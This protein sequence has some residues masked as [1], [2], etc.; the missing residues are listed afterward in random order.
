MVF[1]IW[2]Q[3]LESARARSWQLLGKWLRGRAASGTCSY[4]A[5]TL[6]NSAPEVD[7]VAGKRD[8]L[9]VV[10]LTCQNSSQQLLDV[11]RP[12][13]KRDGIAQHA[14]GLI[15]P[16]QL[17]QRRREIEGMRYARG[18]SH[19]SFLTGS[20]IL[21]AT[22]PGQ[23]R[24]E[25]PQASASDGLSCAALRYASAASSKRRTASRLTA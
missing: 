4:G 24:A 25:V 6:A 17:V 5:H 20:R 10:I 13:L 3:P 8:G 18:E 14:F 22:Q 7:R 1:G 23:E 2:Q 21:P 19:R 9:V 15:Q 11:G 12:R 16:I